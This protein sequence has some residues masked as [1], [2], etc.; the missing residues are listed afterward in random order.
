MHRSTG[1]RLVA[2]VLALEEWA[3]RDPRERR[4]LEREIGTGREGERDAAL[5]R[6]WLAAAPSPDLRERLDRVAS[7]LAAL[8]GLLVAVGLFLGW[9]AA[10]A[11]FQIEVHAGRINVV[12]CL[13]L[14]VALP[15]VTLLLGL[16]LAAIGASPGRDT[17]DRGGPMSAFVSRGL[18]R[19]MPPRTRED[20]A[21]LLGRTRAHRVLYGRVQ[22]LQVLLLLQWAG[23]GYVLGALAATGL[24]I[25]FTDLAFGWSTTL[26]VDAT[27]VHRLLAAVATPWS[28]LWPEASPTLELVEATRHFRAAP[29]PHVHVVDPVVYG[30]WWPFLV[31]ALV[32]YGVLPRLA[33]I[34]MLGL[35]LAR[36]GERAMQRTPGVDRLLDRLRTPQVE[37]R[38]ETPEGEV[39][40]ASV[41]RVPERAPGEVLGGALAASAAGRS[42]PPP[43][44]VEWAEAAGGVDPA[45]RVGTGEAI[46]LAAGGRRSLEQDA[47]AVA[48]CAAEPGPVGVLVRAYEPPLL[49]LLDLLV[50]L[51]R[52]VGPDRELAV[53]LIEGH[54][55]GPIEGHPGGAFEGRAGSLVEG[56]ARDRDAWRRKLRT[57]GDPGI[58]VAAIDDGAEPEGGAEDG[59]SGADGPAMDPPSD[60]GSAR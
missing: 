50:D 48:R 34:A 56:R 25:V 47:E 11:L 42:G 15:F 21:I 49:E 51:R 53:L 9:A 59:S 46:V 23:L 19:L 41:D 60:G 16:L 40:R 28:G 57:L 58:V 10:A 27:A 35:L 31:A 24:F 17:A 13:A 36:A 54:T 6:D 7:A 30:G 43:L 14:L 20:V 18:A 44:L 22:R 38:A 12:L 33:A 8:R 55:G 3:D 26:E 1:V 52:A 32:T 29:V 4:R 39:G 5:L 2:L 45:A 37:T